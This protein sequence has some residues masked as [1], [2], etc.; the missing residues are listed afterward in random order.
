MTKGVKDG[1]RLARHIG[2]IAERAGRVKGA[3]AAAVHF[4]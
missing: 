1:K 4:M 3:A 2:I